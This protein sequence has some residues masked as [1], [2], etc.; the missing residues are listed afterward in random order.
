MF[1]G[2][3]ENLTGKQNRVKEF[4]GKAR[5]LMNSG[6]YSRF[7]NQFRLVSEDR[8]IFTALA[9]ALSLAEQAA[10]VAAII[11]NKVENLDWYYFDLNLNRDFQLDLTKQCLNLRILTK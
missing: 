10:R 6:I 2:W 5:Q 4:C 3:R 1:L 11:L 9:G 7:D 8:M